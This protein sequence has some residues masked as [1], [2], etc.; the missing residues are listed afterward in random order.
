MTETNELILS[1]RRRDGAVVTFDRS[2]IV[3]AIA[4]AFLNDANGMP[5]HACASELMPA[6]RDKVQRFTDQV[7]HAL[8]RRPDAAQH[9]VDIEDI[10]DQV[11]LALMRDG[12]HAIAR[13]YVL[14]RDQRRKERIAKAARST[15]TT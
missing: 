10:Q 11:E 14:Y 2:R 5:R 1:V 13:D 6:E 7:V 9:P 4:L 12:E 15:V 3:R 8:S